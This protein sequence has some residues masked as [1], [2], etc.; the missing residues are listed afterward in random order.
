MVSCD[1]VSVVFSVTVSGLLT[2]MT[3]LYVMVVIS[4][5]HAVASRRPDSVT[6]TSS[7][8]GLM[9]RSDSGQVYVFG[10]RDADNKNLS[11]TQV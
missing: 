8:V 7:V 4:I 6:K 5:W 1:A 2:L 11:W 3:Q 10:G 9:W